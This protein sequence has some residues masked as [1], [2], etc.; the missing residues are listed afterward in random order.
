MVRDPAASLPQHQ[1]T[2]KAV[3]ALYR[4]LNASDVTFEAPLHPQWEQTPTALN[5]HTAWGNYASQI[6]SAGVLHAQRE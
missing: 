6:L 3:K 2:C 4:L 1:Q 5:G